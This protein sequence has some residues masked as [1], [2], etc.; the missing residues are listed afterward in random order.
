MGHVADPAGRPGQPEPDRN[1]FDL[2]INGSGF[3]PVQ[4]PDGTTSYTRDGALRVDAQGQLVTANGY[5][6]APAI[7]VPPDAASVTVGADGVVSALVPGN[8]A[9]V[10]IGQLQTATFVNPAGLDPSGRAGIDHHPRRRQQLGDLEVFAISGIAGPPPTPRVSTSIKRSASA[11]W[12]RWFAVRRVSQASAAV[13]TAPS[14]PLSASPRSRSRSISPRAA[15][16]VPTAV[17]S[18]SRRARSGLRVRPVRTAANFLIGGSSGC[19]RAPAI[20]APQL[21]AARQ[22]GTALASALAGLPGAGR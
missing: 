4:M 18:R 16:S 5:P 15:S 1:P 2:A 14:A 10:Q 7:A 19:S 11:S 6:I 8:A 12:R 20:I 17:N 22:S 21:A 13:R 9:P 3:L